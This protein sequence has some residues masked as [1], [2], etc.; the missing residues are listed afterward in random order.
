MQFD[1]DDKNNDQKLLHIFTKVFSKLHCQAHI[2]HCIIDL[3]KKQNINNRSS[4]TFISIAFSIHLSRIY[5]IKFLLIFMVDV[6]TLVK[7]SFFFNKLFYFFILKT[8]KKLSMRRF[9]F[10]WKIILINR[11]KRYKSKLF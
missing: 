3:L 11:E 9:N 6:M 5:K 4:Y 2:L 8:L 7:M 1:R 10:L